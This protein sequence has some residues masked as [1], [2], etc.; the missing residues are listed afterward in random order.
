[1]SH[2][3]DHT[4][5][6]TPLADPMAADPSGTIAALGQLEQQTRA[7]RVTIACDGIT[8]QVVADYLAA[9]EA[10]AAAV[11]GLVE[12]PMVVDNGMRDA[13]RKSAGWSRAT[14]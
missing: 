11:R 8:A 6:I 4:G 3:I 13:M 14:T 7:V 2:H 9:M 1:M 5:T 10:A 12:A